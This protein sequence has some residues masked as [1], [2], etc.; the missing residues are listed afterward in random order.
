MEGKKHWT[1]SRETH[2]PCHH[3]MDWALRTWEDPF[4]CECDYFPRLLN[5]VLSTWANFYSFISSLFSP[6]PILPRTLNCAQNIHNRKCTSGRQNFHLTAKWRGWQIL[7]SKINSKIAQI[8]KKKKQ[9]QQ[10]FPCSGS[11]PKACNHQRSVYAWKLLN[12][13]YK[14]GHSGPG[15]LSCHCPSWRDSEILQDRA[16]HED[17]QLQGHRRREITQ[18]GTVGDGLA[19]SPVH[20]N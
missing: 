8:D 15:L 4:H 6:T 1:R 19:S 2:V 18:L 7:S 11:H 17:Q 5:E 16:G 12:F 20:G 10:P 9:Q 13:R 14:E 3:S